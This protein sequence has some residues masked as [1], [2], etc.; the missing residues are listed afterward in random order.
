MQTGLSSVMT[1]K[2]P[3][4]SLWTTE[5]SVGGS[6][7]SLDVADRL[8]CTTKVLITEQFIC[9]TPKDQIFQTSAECWH[10]TPRIGPDAFT[11]LGDRL[12]WSHSSGLCETVGQ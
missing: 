2:W 1:W 8:F 3:T 10:V 5:S 12:R 6:S 4:C 9:L 7:S 11:L